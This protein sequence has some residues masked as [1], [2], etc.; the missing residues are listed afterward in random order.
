MT[1]ESTLVYIALAFIGGGAVVSYNRLV[2]ARNLVEEAWSGIDVQLKRRHDLIPNLVEVVKGY[3]GHERGLMERVSS[4]RSGGLSTDET[5]AGV[6]QSE[7]VWAG[8]LKQ[9]FAL[10]ESYP[11]LKADEN[12]RQLHRALSDV[13]DHLQYARR[14]YNGAVRDLNILVESVPSNLI[15]RI[16]G[17]HAA[18]FFEVEYATERSAPDVLL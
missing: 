14:Y 12:F 4:L 7:R 11:D 13:E 18:K 8:E 1:M 9:V 17:I 2:R 15:A 5:K 3:A 16:V 6:E 10:V